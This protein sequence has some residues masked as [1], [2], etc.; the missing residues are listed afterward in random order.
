MPDRAMQHHILLVDD[1]TAIT[2]Y[3]SELLGM[4]QYRVTP[5]NASS[6]ALEIFSVAPETFDLVITDMSLPGMSGIELAGRILQQRPEI[7]VIL[8][9]GYID[10]K[11]RQLIH[12]TGIRAAFNKPVNSMTLINSIR[13]LL[14]PPQS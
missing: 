4:N 3:L 8:C 6:L 5:C 13:Q 9:S 1:E 11:T 2:G 14:P 7:P 12:K 10:E